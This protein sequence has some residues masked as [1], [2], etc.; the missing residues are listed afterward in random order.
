MTLRCRNGNEPYCCV[1]NPAVHVCQ[2]DWKSPTNL[3]LFIVG[4]HLHEKFSV[5]WPENHQSTPKTLS[6]CTA[7][8]AA[9]TQT[10][11]CYYAPASLTPPK[12]VLHTHTGAYTH[13]H[14]VSLT[15]PLLFC[16]FSTP[17]AAAAAR[18]GGEERGGRGWREGEGREARP[19]CS[20][21][22]A[23]CLHCC[24][25]LCNTSGI[26]RPLSPARDGGAAEGR[27]C[28]EGGA[29]AKRETF[30]A[31]REKERER[32]K[33]SE[34]VS[35]RQRWGWVIL[36]TVSC[37]RSFAGLWFLNKSG[38]K[39]AECKQRAWRHLRMSFL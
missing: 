5:L 24:G 26:L 39:N 25:S 29:W 31:E 37:G 32:K 19:P 20:H 6:W 2:E 8:T 38:W 7:S 35:E 28:V 13:S 27:C 11:Y 36:L 34:W 23:E 17:L 16:A 15:L 1:R 3:G 18:E 30:L 14:R 22:R 4:L 33:A 9:K 10:H 12:T 21:G